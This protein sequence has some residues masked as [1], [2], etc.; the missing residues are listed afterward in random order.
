MC[1]KINLFKLKS[2]E[3]IRLN[4]FSA[5]NFV[6]ESGKMGIYFNFVISR[7]PRDMP[8]GDTVQ[9][10]EMPWI[11]INL[12]HEKLIKKYVRA[13]QQQI[14]FSK[15]ETFLSQRYESKK[16]GMFS[17]YISIFNS[18]NSLHERNPSIHSKKQTTRK[19]KSLCEKI[20]Q[21]LTIYNDVPVA[22]VY[23]TSYWFA[24][25]TEKKKVQRKSPKLKYL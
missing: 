3:I 17:T 7:Q 14:N 21:V 22:D 20:G 23:S 13:I 12:N 11:A 2:S 25:S 4:T 6:F 18:L 19:V 9:L 8:L 10:K 1:L 16:F 5:E 15:G 24:Q